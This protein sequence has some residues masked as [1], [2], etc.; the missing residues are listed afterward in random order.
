MCTAHNTICIIFL[1]I[2]GKKK[3]NYNATLVLEYNKKNIAIKFVLKVIIDTIFF[4][5]AYLRYTLGMGGVLDDVWSDFVGGGSSAADYANDPSVSNPKNAQELGIDISNGFKSGAS[6]SQAC[7][8]MDS[9]SLYALD[10]ADCSSNARFICIKPCK[11]SNG[12][13]LIPF[14]VISKKH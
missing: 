14:L 7:T 4:I 2:E 3:Q 9:T 12:M 5:K 10:G 6:Y 1:S 11:N 13:Y 8:K